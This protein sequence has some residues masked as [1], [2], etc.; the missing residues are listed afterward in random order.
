MFSVLMDDFINFM[1][2][3][4]KIGIL[5]IMITEFNIV[6]GLDRLMMFGVTLSGLLIDEKYTQSSIII[7]VYG[8]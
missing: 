3:M 1:A 2:F 6:S 7:D 8:N 4:M 5:S